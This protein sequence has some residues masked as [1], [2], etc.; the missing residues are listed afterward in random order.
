MSGLD[1]FAPGYVY[2]VTFRNGIVKVGGTHNR[3]QRLASVKSLGRHIAGEPLSALSFIHLHVGVGESLTRRMARECGGVPLDGY[4]EWLSGVNLSAFTAR[5]H[6]FWPSVLLHPDS[7]FW[8]NPKLPGLRGA[9]IFNRAD[10]DALLT[11]PTT[12]DAEV[13]S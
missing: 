10:I 6:E 5:L 9:Y 11:P 12:A 3:K 7:Q 8:I 1:S 13:A 2:V 4:R